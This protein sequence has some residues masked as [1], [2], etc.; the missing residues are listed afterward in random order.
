MLQYTTTQHN[1]LKM[2]IEIITNTP[3]ML[4]HGLQLNISF[5]RN[6][7]VILKLFEALI[8]MCVSYKMIAIIFNRNCL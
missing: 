6:L 1:N 2:K 7:I 8:L 4:H 3:R 5:I